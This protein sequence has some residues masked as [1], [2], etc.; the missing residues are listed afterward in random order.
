MK[1]RIVMAGVVIC[2]IGFVLGNLEAS[3]R[4]YFSSSGPTFGGFLFIPGLVTLIIGLFLKE[5]EKISI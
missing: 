3:S 5:G 4:S 1:K 2:L